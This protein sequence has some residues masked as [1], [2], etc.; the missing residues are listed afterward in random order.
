M[1]K[2]TAHRMNGYIEAHANYTTLCCDPRWANAFMER[3]MRMVERDKNHPCIFGWSLGNESGHGENH[4]RL[5]ESP[6][7]GATVIPSINR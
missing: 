5:V 4:E 2:N 1:N 7:D 3:G 6:I